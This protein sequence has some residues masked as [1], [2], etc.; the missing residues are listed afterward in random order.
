MWPLFVFGFN[1]RPRCVDTPNFFCYM[2]FVWVR[3]TPCNCMALYPTMCTDHA[4]AQNLLLCIS[5]FAGLF[6]G[7]LFHFHSVFKHTTHTLSQLWDFNVFF[8]HARTQGTRCLSRKAKGSYMPADQKVDR[9]EQWC[10]H[11]RPSVS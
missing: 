11:L 1:L 5:A 9:S 10:T 8:L 4:L 3:D 2:C 6:E 7:L